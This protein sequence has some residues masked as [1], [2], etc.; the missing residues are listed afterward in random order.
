MQEDNYRTYFHYSKEFVG[1][2][3]N[4]FPKLFLGTA[5]VAAGM[6][7][8]YASEK[9]DYGTLQTDI[10]FYKHTLKPNYNNTPTLQCMMDHWKDGSITSPRTDIVVKTSDHTEKVFEFKRGVL[11]N[12]PEDFQECKP[13]MF[14]KFN[15]Y[16]A[17]IPKGRQVR[18]LS[19]SSGLLKINYHHETQFES[20]FRRAARKVG[21]S[22]FIR[23]MLVLSAFSGFSYLSD[24]LDK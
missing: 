13:A 19:D 18:T 4:T 10:M 22:G 16:W 12:V 3:D 23:V 7:C 5:F 24:K 21:Q 6:Y 2:I 11:C 17:K 14:D 9:V 15:S 20:R 1:E 8:Y